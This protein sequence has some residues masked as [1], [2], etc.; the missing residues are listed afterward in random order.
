[1]CLISLT[2]F[3][4]N[5]LSIYFRLIKVIKRILR[6]FLTFKRH[7]PKS[8]AFLR[9]WLSYNAYLYHFAVLLKALLQ[10]VVSYPTRKVTHVQHVALVLCGVVTTCFTTI[11]RTR[12]STVVTV[13]LV[14]TTIT[15]GTPV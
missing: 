10:I 2:Y 5:I 7:K 11:T 13:T 14:T 9:E 12:R 4:I 8:T 3:H 15:G 6:A 1:M